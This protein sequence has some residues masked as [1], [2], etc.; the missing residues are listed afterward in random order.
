MD[1]APLINSHF[2]VAVQQLEQLASL[3]FPLD[4]NLLIPVS[5]LDSFTSVLLKIIH[6]CVLSTSFPRSSLKRP[7]ISVWIS[8]SGG[9]S[10]CKGFFPVYCLLG[11]EI[12]EHYVSTGPLKWK[13]WGGTQQTEIVRVPIINSWPK[14]RLMEQIPGNIFYHC[15]MPCKDGLCTHNFSLLRN[16][17]DILQADGIIY[18]K[19]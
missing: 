16:S 6:A 2:L 15:C 7:M 3:N 5:C 10:E 9:V 18:L 1:Y 13:K 4:R 14:Q 11:I 19:H 17:T 12:A 8:H